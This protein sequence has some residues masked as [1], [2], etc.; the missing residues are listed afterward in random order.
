MPVRRLRRTAGAVAIAGGALVSPGATAA[1]RVPPV[2]AARSI[3]SGPAGSHLTVRLTKPVRV[4]HGSGFAT[5]TVSGGRLAGVAIT[6]PAGA[7]VQ[8]V[9]GRVDTCAFDPA[10]CAILDFPSVSGSGTHDGDHTVLPAG[11]YTVTLLGEKGRRVVAALRLPGAGGGLMTARTRRA[12]TVNVRD[13]TSSLPAAGDAQP[14][15][16]GTVE[17]PAVW[18]RRT[19]VGTVFRGDA[20]VV[21]SA[22]FGACVH[23][24]SSPQVPMTCVNPESTG[25]S[26]V[27]TS[28][29]G[30]APGV[31]LPVMR[32]PIAFTLSANG[33]VDHPPTV[34]VNGRVE[35]VRSRV[36]VIVYSI[37]VG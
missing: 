13:V 24:G 14:V 6:T 26:V 2:L 7:W 36:R 33:V 31:C 4:E 1:P 20:E 11:T 35:A 32:D 10:R 16:H 9:S 27:S 23:D 28:E 34:T 5:V 29:C 18:N 3:V 37:T 12:G 22:T 21:R 17:L 30:F 8:Q 15:A 25:S 19:L